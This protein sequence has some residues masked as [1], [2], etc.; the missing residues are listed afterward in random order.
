MKN[1][2]FK[3]WKFGNLF[4]GLFHNTA[5]PVI[6][7]NQISILILIDKIRARQTFSVKSVC[8]CV[9]SVVPDSL[10]PHGL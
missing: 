1:L 9:F 2:Q 7:I 5:I 10:R 8:L 4:G 6:V 3:R